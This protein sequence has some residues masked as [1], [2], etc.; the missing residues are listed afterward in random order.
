M[1]DFALVHVIQG[2]E[3][4]LKDNF[5]QI[6]IEFSFFPQKPVQLPT[7]AQFHHQ[8][9]VPFIAEESVKLDDVGMVEEFLDLD[10]SD[11]LNY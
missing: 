10:F 6:L 1:D 8:V 4:I 5:G 2:L 3:G 11:Q 9:N 7:G